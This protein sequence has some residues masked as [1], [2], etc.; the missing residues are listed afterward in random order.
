M[1]YRVLQQEKEIEGQKYISCAIALYEDKELIRIIN[2]VF[3]DVNEAERFVEICNRLKVSV[4][5]IDDIIE[6][7]LSV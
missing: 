6:D 2:D 1:K 7:W 5:H 4:L 3:S